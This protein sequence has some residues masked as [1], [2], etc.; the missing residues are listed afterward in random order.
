MQRDDDDDY[1]GGGDEE[2]GIEVSTSFFPLAWIFLFCTPRIAIEDRVRKRPW[3]TYFFPV[4]P[5]RYR[6]EIWF[7][8]LFWQECG[9][10]SR[11]VDV[12]P[13]EVTRVSYFM[14]PFVLM[15]GSMNVSG[16]F[17]RSEITRN[18]SGGAPMSKI[19]VYALLGAP[20]AVIV[21]I[22]ACCCGMSVIGSLTGNK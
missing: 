2:T 4:P 13:G 21:G 22:F 12:E 15:S 14:W 16:P 18:S 6:V 19:W 9:K 20:V 17:P 3:G 8:Y 5:G 7:A 10:N 11:N 1:E